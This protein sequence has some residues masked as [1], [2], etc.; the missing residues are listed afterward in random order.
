M[1]QPVQM[2]IPRFVFFV[3]I[4]FFYISVDFSKHPQCQY[5]MQDDYSTLRFPKE[6][7][8]VQRVIWTLLYYARA[9]DSTLLTAWTHITTQKS[10]PTQTTMEK[11]N[12]LQDYVNT[13]GRVFVRFHA[14]DMILEVDSNSSYLILPKSRRRYAGYVWLLDHLSIHKQRLHNGAILVLCKR[15]R[16]VVTS[17]AKAETTGIQKQHF[18]FI[19]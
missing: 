9:I 16:H 17:E 15:I 5:A 3:L 12:Q 18:H 14:S 1:A 4:L 8:Y 13:Y 19:T 11:C 6:T 7:N 2:H 10:S